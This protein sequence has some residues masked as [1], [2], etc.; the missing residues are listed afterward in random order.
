MHDSSTTGLPFGHHLDVRWDNVTNTNA[1]VHS[2]S[3]ITLDMESTADSA[4]INATTTKRKLADDAT[5]TDHVSKK[6]RS[7]EPTNA[8]RR[9]L[10]PAAPPAP[11][12]ERPSRPPDENSQDSDDSSDDDIGPAMPSSKGASQVPQRPIASVQPSTQ[13]TSTSSLGLQ[14]DEWMLMPPKQDDLAARMDPSKIRARGFNS[15]K[16]AR[17]PGVGDPDS[18]IWTDTPED[19]RKRLQNQ[20]LGVSNSSAIDST[21]EIRAMQK[22]QEE[23]ALASKV[24]ASRGPSL[25]DQHQSSS[26]KVDEDDPSKRGFDRER[27]MGGGALMT[28][29][30]RK[31]LLS[32]AADFSSKFS[33]GGFL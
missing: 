33:G 32:K 28:D 31:A 19:R 11:L 16:G 27:D 24:K 18:T 14:R 22:R 8:P 15:G 26:R 17:Q 25:Y 13:T 10:G 3:E 1:S 2:G 7:P 21:R 23:A 30:K 29:S 4:I 5:E 9:V 12:S 6:P 20:V